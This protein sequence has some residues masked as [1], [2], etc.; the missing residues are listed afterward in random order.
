[1]PQVARLESTL[2]FN[3]AAFTNGIERAEK[4]AATFG[5]RVEATFNN[6]FRRTPG[7]RAEKALTGLV[8]DIATGSLSQGIMSFAGRLTGLGLAAGVGVGVAIEL[9]D[10]LYDSVKEVRAAH[11]GLRQQMNKPIS[12]LGGL[13]AEGIGEQTNQLQAAM[14][15]L[16]EVQQSFT[17]GVA[18]YLSDFAHQKGNII[19]NPDFGKSQMSEAREAI[20]VQQRINQL[21]RERGKIELEQASARKTTKGDETQFAL[22]E[23]YFKSRQAEAAVRLEGGKG[24][25]DRLKAIKTAEED[26]TDEIVHRGEVREA[27]FKTAEKLLKLERSNVPADKKKALAASISLDAINQQLSSPDISVSE[28]RSL[29]LQKLKGEMEL[30]DLTQNP[31]N[32]FAFGT[33]AARDAD[34]EQGFGSIAQRNRDMN[35]SSVWGSLGASAMNRGESAQNSPGTAI[36]ANLLQK[37]T[38]L[39]AQVWATP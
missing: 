4:R 11:E 27:E 36:I 14:E 30:R 19:T 32:K 8:G 23:L 34:N 15:K 5:G 39:T 22:S 16:R 6:L 1:M 17:H 28:K 7:R 2:A 24:V 33:I 26:L 20:D 25:D 3:D 35:D 12:L 29:T 9:F 13:S 38:D 18:G 31:R 21:Q 10:K 37:L